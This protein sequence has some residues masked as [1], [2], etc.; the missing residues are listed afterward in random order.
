MEDKW[1]LKKRSL[2]ETVIDLLKNW[3][4]LW[5]T[6]HGSIDNGLNNMLACLAAYNFIDHKPAI[7]PS[8]RNTILI[9]YPNYRRTHVM[10]LN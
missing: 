5:H 4:D 6:R 1:L 10:L 7:N 2:L 9:Y 8:K 3:M